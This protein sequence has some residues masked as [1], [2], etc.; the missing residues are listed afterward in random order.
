MGRTD[1]ERIIG[2]LRQI[3]MDPFGSYTKPLRD[4]AGRRTA[5]VGGWR[6]IYVVNREER[7]VDVSAIGPRGETYRGL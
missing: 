5:R 6:I 4:P 3:G 2:R 1:Q 7:V